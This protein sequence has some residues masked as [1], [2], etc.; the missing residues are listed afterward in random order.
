MNSLKQS[1]KGQVVLVKRAVATG[2]TDVPL[3]RIFRCD[4]GAGCDPDTAGVDIRGEFIGNA[5]LKGQTHT[6]NGKTDI[7]RMAT[8][9]EIDLAH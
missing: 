3:T 8:Q 6:I 7:E 5:M 1:I 4:S 2:T 9:I